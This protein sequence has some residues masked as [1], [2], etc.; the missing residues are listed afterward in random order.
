MTTLFFHH[1]LNFA[2]ML[3]SDSQSMSVEAAMIGTPSIKDP[4][5]CAASEMTIG[6]PIFL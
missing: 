2:E 5:E 6:L 1:I 4:M 3:I